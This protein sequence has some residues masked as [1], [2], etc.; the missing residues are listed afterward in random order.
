MPGEEYKD[1]FCKPRE[2]FQF[3]GLQPD[4]KALDICTGFGYLAKHMSKITTRNVDAHNGSEWR[5]FFQSVGVDAAIGD[6]KQ[7]GVHHYYATLNDPA[8]STVEHYDVITMQNTYHDL[9]D[10]PVDRRLFLLSIHR[11]LKKDGKFLLVDHQ[12]GPGRGAKDAGANR[13]LHRIEERVVRAELEACGFRIVKTSD[14]FQSSKDHYRSS[15]WTNPM[16]ETDRF[17]FLCMKA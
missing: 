10:M 13:G 2:L 9:Y 15:A 1:I 12:A 5:G 16:K 8:R 14:M 6:M 7:A 4:H 11:A 3:A 17:V